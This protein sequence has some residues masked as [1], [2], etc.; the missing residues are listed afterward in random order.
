MTVLP[1]GR[2]T[3]LR[4]YS[5]VEILELPPPEYLVDG[6]IEKRA[7]HGQIAP[8]GHGKT[9][10]S[11]DVAFCVATGTPFHGREVKQ[12]NVLYIYAEAA[13]GL[14]YRAIAWKVEHGLAPTDQCGVYFVLNPVDLMDDRGHG[15]EDLIELIRMSVPEPISLVV[16]DTLAKCFGDKDENSTPHMNMFTNRC[17]RIK[18]VFNCATLVNQHTGWNEK[19]HRGNRAFESNFDNVFKCQMRNQKSQSIQLQF[20]KQKDGHESEPFRLQLVEVPVA[21]RTTCVVRTLDQEDDGNVEVLSEEALKQ[22]R[23]LSDLGADGATY[24]EWEK[25]AIGLGISESSFKRILD[26]LRDGEYVSSPVEGQSARGFK[27]TLTPKGRAAVGVQEHVDPKVP[28]ETHPSASGP[29]RVQPQA[30]AELADNVGSN[31]G[32]EGSMDP[33]VG[34]GSG[35]GAYKAPLEPNTPAV[36]NNGQPKACLYCAMPWPFGCE[37]CEHDCTGKEVQRV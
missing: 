28:S 10:I 20:T 34:S 9:F 24:T 14:P 1:N 17:D 27:N 13:P 31:S 32:P 30:A 15:V 25:A 22:L 26:V 35:G 3:H 36:P 16:F 4:I 12:G 23:A 29:D 19:R 5:D 37:F 6:L 2:E 18:D 7:S 33:S 21:D 11:L 8:S